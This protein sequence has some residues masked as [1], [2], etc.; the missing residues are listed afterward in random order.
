MWT[1]RR[2]ASLACAVLVGAAAQALSADPAKTPPKQRALPVATKAWKGDFDKM[3]E[4]RMV[5]VLVPYSRTLYYNDKGRERGVTADHVRDF[6]QFINR[7]YAKV[8]GKRPITVYMIPTTRDELLEDVAN[9]EGDIAAGNL[10]VTDERRRGVDFFAPADQR[11]M[12]EVVLTGPKS[13]VIATADDL[14]G[15]TVHCARDLE[16]SRKPRRPE[17]T[18]AARRQ[19]RREAATSFPTLSRTRT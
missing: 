7:K 19:A 17:R 8:L 3:V 15:R 14:S 6:E 11:P 4:R 18:L 10:T 12:S 9:G 13:P 5:R 1:S 16:L 2:F